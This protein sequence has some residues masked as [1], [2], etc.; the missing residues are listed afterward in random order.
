MSK[1]ALVIAG[2]VIL[3]SVAIGGCIKKTLAGDY[4]W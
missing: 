3:A 1:K 2:I 4:L